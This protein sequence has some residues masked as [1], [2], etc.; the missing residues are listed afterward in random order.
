VSFDSKEQSG[1]A[2]Q[3]YELYLFQSAALTFALT[4]ADE[5]I[6]YLGEQYV[7]T[8][9]TR[10]E[11]E[12]SSEV[13]SGMIK[14]YIPKDHALARMLLPYLPSSPIAVTVFGSHYA[15]SE[16]VV[17]FTGVVASAR[18]TDQCELTCNAAAYLLQRK[19][20]QQLYQAPC[21]HIFGD[22]GCGADLAAHTYA[23]TVTA[24]DATGTVLTIPAFASLPD[25]VQGGY[26]QFGD[27]Y[28]MVVAHA[29][30]TVTLISPIAG[31]TAPAAVHGT[32]GCA[33][34]FSACAHYKRTISFLGF[35]LIPTI[36]PFDGSASIG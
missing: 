23:G 10:T 19:I 20:P 5:A 2:A 34:T 28:R 9:I 1:F 15:D 4:S 6:T 21:S 12:H 35:D 17:L 14:I 27:E 33:L 26:L 11:A 18:F 30:S 13:V 36:N 25:T 8:T 3:P 29:G 24:I 32:A 16:T 31:M 22:A 7:P